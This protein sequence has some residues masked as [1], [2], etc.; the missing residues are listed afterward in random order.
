ML[1]NRQ[2]SFWW[3]LLRRK[4]ITRISACNS[5]Q[6]A[7]PFRV[8]GDQRVPRKTVRRSRFASASGE[9]R[10]ELPRTEGLRPEPISPAATQTRLLQRLRDGVEFAAEARPD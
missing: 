9:S 6:A 3:R 4:A 10:K 2:R 1:A 8:A 5:V 7:G